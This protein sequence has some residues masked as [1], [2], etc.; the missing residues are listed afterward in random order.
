MT[1][2]GS[3]FLRHC[4][5]CGREYS[6]GSHI[7]G[8]GTQRVLV[9][10]GFCCAECQEASENEVNKRMWIINYTGRYL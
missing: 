1:I 3:P 6:R 10:E 9:R 7:E 2:I 8:L 5:E 4:D